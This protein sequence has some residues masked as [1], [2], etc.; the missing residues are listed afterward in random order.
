MILIEWASFVVELIWALV[1]LLLLLMRAKKIGRRVAREARAGRK[2]NVLTEWKERASQRGEAPFLVAAGEETGMALRSLSYA[3]ADELSDAVARWLDPK[4]DPGETVAMVMGTSCEFCVVL[5]GVAKAGCR[6]ALINV[7]LRGGP[8]AHALGEALGDRRP[9]LAV[10]DAEFAEATRLSFGGGLVVT[11]N[12]AGGPQLVLPLRPAPRPSSSSSSSSR[13]DDD[14][15]KRRA[16]RWSRRCASWIRHRRRG[17]QQTTSPSRRQHQAPEVFAYVYTSGTTGLPKAA[18]ISPAR[19]WAAGTCLATLA[20]LKPNDRV[21]CALPL[22]HAT[23]GLLGFWGVVRGGCC[24]VLRRKFSASRFATDLAV[25]RATGC[26]Y[27]GE[28]ARYLVDAPTNSVVGLRFA[29][30]NGLPRDAWDAFKRRYGIR[31]IIEFYGSTEGN[32]NLFN[33]AGVTGACGLVP[34]PFL[35][36]YPIFVAKLQIDADVVDERATGAPQLARDARGLCI[37]AKPNEPGE[38]LGRIDVADPSRSFDG[39]ADSVATRRKVITDVKRS[40][41]A[42]FRSGDL[43]TMDR[44]GFVYFLD[45]TGDTFRWKG[46]NVSTVELQRAVLDVAHHLVVETVAYGVRVPGKNS[47]LG[48][49]GVLA[50]VLQPDAPPTW[51]I[52]LYAILERES[53]LAPF[54]VPRFLRLVN[55][56]PKTVTHK[57][58]KNDFLSDG[59]DPSRCR[60]DPLYVRDPNLQAFVPLTDDALARVASGDLRL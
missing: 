43:V 29:F 13:R 55:H 6:A 50:L 52:D 25:S 51:P 37:A 48:K 1:D 39:Y 4:T 42:Y 21:Y 7:A 59:I 2:W 9:R 17:G 41:D 14:D 26:L 22:Y 54:A 15:G 24:L 27:V 38:L 33:N 20:R 11:P 34:R 8:L 47:G 23:A 46:E 16:A 36:L 10:A 32:V 49:C 58:L 40:G 19:A 5:L 45:R 28:M 35:W 56:L 31:R 60:P 30:G 57:Y 18:K 53:G 44:V 3:E 12:V